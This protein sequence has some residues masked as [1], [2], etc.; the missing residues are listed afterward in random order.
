MSYAALSSKHPIVH[1]RKKRST[2]SLSLQPSDSPITFWQI[3]KGDQ[4]NS[5]KLLTLPMPNQSCQHL[6]LQ[7]ESR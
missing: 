7:Q 2:G 5:G 3:V 1:F 6:L 4:P